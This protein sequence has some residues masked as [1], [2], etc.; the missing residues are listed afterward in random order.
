MIYTQYVGLRSDLIRKHGGWLV[1]VVSAHASI[2]PLLSKLKDDSLRVDECL[3]EDWKRWIEGRANR[4]IIDL[5]DGASLNIL[6]DRLDSNGI[7]YSL[8]TESSIGPEPLAISLKPYN[9]GR[10]APYFR[11]FPRF[12]PSTEGSS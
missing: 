10:V 8:I 6:R 7:E 2:V 9:K 4:E 3:D 12:N 5:K 11:D 1:A